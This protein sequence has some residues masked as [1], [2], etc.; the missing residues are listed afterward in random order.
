MS[1][2]LLVRSIVLSGSLSAL[3]TASTIRPAAPAA[4]TAQQ[5][6]GNPSASTIADQIDL[7]LTV[8]NSGLALVRDV[9][10]IALSNGRNDLEFA[11]ISATIN[12]ATVHLRSLTEPGRL[13]VLEQNYQYDL[14]EPE[15]LLRKYVG[16]QVTLV[17]RETLDGTSREQSVTAT[18]LAYNNGPVWKIGDEIV[19]GLDADHLRFLGVP[20]NLR[21]RPTLIWTLDNSGARQHR[22]EAS[23][24]AN[25]LQWNAD[26]VLTVGRDDRSASLGGWVTLVN[27]S[28]TEFPNARLQLIAGDLNR[29]KIGEGRRDEMEAV[30]MRAA[31]DA[32]AFAR[33]TFSEYHLY[34]LERRTSIAN[35]ETKQISLLEAEGVPVEK[36][37]VVEG[38]QFYYHN[39]QHPGAPLKDAVRVYYRLRNDTKS[40]LG[41]PLPSGT[42]RV[43]Q[44]DSQ[45][46][47][48]FAGE[49]HIG[50]TP[51]DETLNLHVG[52]AF[53]VVCER[54]QTDF[55]ALGGN[56][57]EFAFEVTLRN[58]KSDAISVNVNEPIGG[59]WEMLDSTY[60]AT[61]TAAWAASFNVAVPAGG[62]STLKYRV[63]ARW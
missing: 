55:D 29:V 31:A 26:Y 34:S 62:T 61:K 25:N 14:L 16:R 51:V 45:G 50:H 41:M 24:L 33:E 4:A 23:Y 28:G 44:S 48:L 15:K 35:N 20:D 37:Y 19:T 10:N 56:L 52:N 63:R 21:S 22:V 58:H 12:P 49:D 9:R 42:V 18:L 2:R 3:L 57:Y 11:D 7:A 17:R 5:P 43:Y 38:Q 60:P 47:L 1:R 32:S 13:S 6:G 59:S 36:A 30:M 53:D 46:G 54:R 39:A 27:Q 40:S 8:Y